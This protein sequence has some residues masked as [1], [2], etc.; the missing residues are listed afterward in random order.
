MINYSAYSNTAS[1]TLPGIV[2][3]DSVQGAV[4]EQ[5]SITFT[6]TFGHTVHLDWGNGTI[7]AISDGSNT[8]TSNYAGNNTTYH[9][10]IYDEITA[11]TLFSITPSASTVNISLDQ[12]KKFKNLTYLQITS[13]KNISGKLE[14]LPHGLSTCI[15]YGVTTAQATYTGVANNMPHSI[16]DL[17]LVGFPDSVSI[18]IDNIWEG[19]SNLVLTAASANNTTATGTCN[20]FPSTLTSFHTIKTYG[21]NVHI[22][23]LPSGMLDFY[24]ENTAQ[25]TDGGDLSN[26]PRGLG[27]FFVVSTTSGPKFTGRYID[28]P[29][30]MYYLIMAD[31]GVITGTPD[32]VPKSVYTTCWLNGLGR[33]STA[34]INQLPTAVNTNLVMQGLTFVGNYEDLPFLHCGL[35]FVDN[36]GGSTVG[37]GTI[38]VWST[39]AITIQDGLTTSELDNLLI[40]FAAT[41]VA[42]T[43]TGDF[44]GAGGYA[45][46]ARSVASNAAVTILQGLGKT[47]LTN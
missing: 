13:V 14:T 22:N 15:L 1:I 23:S 29:R 42:G 25:V 34:H 6:K 35:Y 9:I 24:S 27:S 31:C 44:R 4:I 46:Q 30:V 47:I 5:V 45:N 8:V 2:L 7:I 18:D 41:A 3:I 32:D 28:L 38:A 17:Q 16:T 39:Q 11:I 19:L 20:S 26:L 10:K 33:G 36:G 21:I 43:A 12:I 40:K 37:A